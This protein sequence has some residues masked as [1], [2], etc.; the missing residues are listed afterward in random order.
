[1]TDRPIIFSGPMVRALLEGHKT[2]T[3]RLSERASK[4]VLSHEG[5][6][7]LRLSVPSPWQKVR[8][9]DRLWVREN[10]QALSYGDYLPC[11]FPPWDLRFAA[12]DSLAESSAEVRGHMWRPSI[13]MPRAA[14]RLT[15]VVTAVKIERLQ[16]ISVGD[17]QAEGCPVKPGADLLD[18]CSDI[19]WW[20]ATWNRIH[21]PG[22]WDANPEVIA[23][24]FAVHRVN[25]DRMER[26]A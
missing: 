7:P 5:D 15:L 11:K 12:T 3:R 9:G 19:E 16:D 22:A 18:D 20:M 6:A 2:M 14:S 8:S 26:A 24:T 1:M 23:L 21:G 13:H 4:P 25:I 10:W 17:I